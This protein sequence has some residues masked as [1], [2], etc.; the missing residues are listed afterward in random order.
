[1]CREIETTQLVCLATNVNQ[2]GFGSRWDFVITSM[3]TDMD[4]IIIRQIS[5]TTAVHSMYFVWCSLTGQVVSAIASD[6][7][8]CEPKTRIIIRGTT[9]T[10]VTFALQS[11]TATNTFA[12]TADVGLLSITLEFVKYRRN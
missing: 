11:L 4:E 3:P 12:S 2:N 7:F 9:P 1:M 6:D 10:T 8:S 5:L